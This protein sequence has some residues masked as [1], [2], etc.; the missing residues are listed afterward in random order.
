V[1]VMRRLRSAGGWL[2][3][4]VRISVGGLVVAAL[5][6]GVLAIGVLVIARSSFDA[7]MVHTGE[8]T[9][10]AQAMFDRGVVAIFAIG[11]AV[12]AAVSIVVSVVLAVRIARP[13]N[14]MSA[15]AR[16]IA[17]GDRAARVP[18]FGPPELRSLAD[19]FNHMAASLE[20]QERVRCDF[21]VNAAHEL[22]T[23]LT[24]LQGY[25]EAL[26]DGVVE[27]SREQFA[28][29]YEEVERLVRLSHSLDS[30]AHARDDQERAAASET[31]LAQTL[32]TAAEVARPSFE[33]K[34]IAFETRIPTRI[35]ARA[36]ADRVSQVLGNL[37]QNASRYTPVSGRVWLS[38]ERSDDGLVVSVINTGD[39]IHQPS[40]HVCSSASIGWTS[41]ERPRSAAPASVWPS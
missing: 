17:A 13:L 36:H 29:L 11:S 15:A 1:R 39:G 28:S 34:S 5:A 10:A 22:R 20:D 14:H 8:S 38:A 6:I 24:N 27:P 16:C 33:S 7:L 37:L 40:C 25:L 19:S 2:G 31:D 18:R 35:R 41:R 32:R 4:A 9:T 26:R 30:L 23:P 12:A 21:I 3:L